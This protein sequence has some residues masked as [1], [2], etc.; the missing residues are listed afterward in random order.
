MTKSKT[1]HYGG[2]CVYFGKTLA[3]FGTACGINSLQNDCTLDADRVTCGSCRRSK[4]FKMA[5]GNEGTIQAINAGA[6]H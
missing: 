2:G 1:I 4:V 5:M 6:V 3:T